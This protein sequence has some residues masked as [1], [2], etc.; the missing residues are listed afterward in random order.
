ML[1][2]GDGSF[3]VVV[4][5]QGPQ[6][7]PAPGWTLS[8]MRRVLAPGGRAAVSV[9]GRVERMPV[10]AALT[11]VLEKRGRAGAS[12]V[13]AVCSLSD[14]ADL[15]AFLAGAG[16]ERIGVRT[17][18]TTVV[19]PS[20]GAFVRQWVPDLVDE[21]QASVAAD[22]EM[23]CARRVGARGLRMAIEAHIAVGSV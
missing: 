11:D 1:P 3:D 18:R 2:F 23:R 12:M 21:D 9:W 19:L 8:E 7:L 20:V 4:Y 6:L 22:L 17:V 10:L 14:P 13:R 16:F 15:R 5:R